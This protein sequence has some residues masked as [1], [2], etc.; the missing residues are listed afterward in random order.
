MDVSELAGD[1]GGCVASLFP[2]LSSSP[3]PFPTTV[4]SFFPP[5][6][7]GHSAESPLLIVALFLSAGDTIDGDE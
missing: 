4:E 2:S 1:R 5:S 7:E 6:L 3:S